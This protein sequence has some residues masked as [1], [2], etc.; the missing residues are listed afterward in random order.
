MFNDI[1]D[2]QDQICSK[3]W[4]SSSQGHNPTAEV[5]RV[6]CSLNKRDYR[7]EFSCGSWRHRW[8]RN[9]A[10]TPQPP[11]YKFNLKGI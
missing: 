6:Y 2:K 11:K 5:G 7:K 3:C 1:I 8:S 4:W 10:E 9:K